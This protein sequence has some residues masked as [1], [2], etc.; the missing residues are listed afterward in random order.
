MNGDGAPLLSWR[1][2]DVRRELRAVGDWSARS[3]GHLV[4]PEGVEPVDANENNPLELRPLLGDVVHVLRERGLR[5]AALAAA[6]SAP[7]ALLLALAARGEV[8]FGVAWGSTLTLTRLADSLAQ[9][10]VTAALI[11]AT[12]KSLAGRESSFRTNVA[13][14]WT[15]LGRAAWTSIVVGLMTVLGLL[16]LV[17]PG[18]VL[19]CGLF[20]AVPVAVVEGLGAGG[21]VARSRE[22]TRGYRWNV[23]GLMVVA[24]IPALFAGVATDA[25]EVAEVPGIAHA[26][27]WLLNALYLPVWAIVATVA[28]WRLRSDYDRRQ[29]LAARF[30]G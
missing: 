16:A 6:V 3:A 12:A 30:G 14:G 8:D 1:G 29:L 11:H 21:A 15:S 25:L 28:Y 27:G 13:L 9:Y 22:L 4:Y 7:G 17:V 19:A 24:A 10:L 23:L 2:L 26:A 18:V 5:F 20:V